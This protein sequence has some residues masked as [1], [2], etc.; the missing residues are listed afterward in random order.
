MNRSLQTIIQ[1]AP[2]TIL[3]F[4]AI[5]ISALYWLAPRVA[6][7][8]VR[9]ARPTKPSDAMTAWFL[10]LW[11]KQE[12]CQRH[13]ACRIT[14]QLRKQFVPLLSRRRR[15]SKEA[16][17]RR[18]IR[19]WRQHGKL[20]LEPPDCASFMSIIIMI[21]VGG[22]IAARKIYP[23]VLSSAH[24]THDDLEPPWVAPLTVSGKRLTA[25]WRRENHFARNV[26]MQ[27]QLVVWVATL[28]PTSGPTSWTIDCA[29]LR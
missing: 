11:C 18:P 15:A 20:L 4:F 26:S 10:H 9:F 1:P 23:S 5:P 24:T 28:G 12:A 29:F 19:A 13:Q 21:S 17:R 8:W 3:L 27:V 25:G 7:P 22:I 6:F 16:S 2:P 14:W